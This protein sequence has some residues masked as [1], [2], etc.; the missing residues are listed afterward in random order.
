MQ[1][2]LLGCGAASL[3][4]WFPALRKIAE[5]SFSGSSNVQEQFF[6]F[7]CSSL[8]TEILWSILI[9]RRITT[10]KKTWTS[11][12]Q[13]WQLQIFNRLKPGSFSSLP[14][15]PPPAC[16][17]RSAA[18]FVMFMYLYNIDYC[19][20]VGKWVVRIPRESGPPRG[21]TVV[22]GNIQNVITQC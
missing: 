1:K 17:M 20:G 6:F 10:S 7:D 2:I 13:L 21:D 12:T 4:E 5:P 9:Q 8:N 19:L 22:Q 14:P 11:S 15:P 16:F 3:D 18:T